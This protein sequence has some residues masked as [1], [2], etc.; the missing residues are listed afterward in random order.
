M[1]SD[2]KCVA[3]AEVGVNPDAARPSRRAVL[4]AGGFGALGVVTLALPSVAAA[5]STGGDGSSGG[6]EPATLA[7]SA[8][9]VEGIAYSCGSPTNGDPDYFALDLWMFAAANPGDD[10]R[11]SLDANPA[12]P[13]TS[14]V[15]GPTPSDEYT[16]FKYRVEAPGG[17][18]STLG[19]AASQGNLNVRI[20]RFESGILVAVSDAIRVY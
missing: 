17:C 20:G 13:W 18:F 1:H 6:G 5:S 8:Y 10:Y 19:T 7:L 2:G 9:P 15:S 12:G 3:P 14:K 11:V 4:S 16:T